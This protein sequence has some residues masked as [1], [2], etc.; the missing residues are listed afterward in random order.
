MK[1][2]AFVVLMIS[3]LALSDL[4]ANEVQFTVAAPNQVGVG[5]RFNVTFRLNKRPASFEGPATFNGFRLL[6]G[7]SQSMSSQTQWVNNQMTMSESYSF[8][9]TLEALTE[10]T[11]TIPV[12]RA[13]VDGNTHTSNQATVV[14]SGQAQQQAQPRSQQ[15]QPQ[16]QA[17]TQQNITDEDIFIRASLSNR[18]PWQGERVTL[19][20]KLYTRVG[21]SQFHLDKLPSFQGLWSEDVTASGQVQ[22]TEEIIDGQRYNVATLKQF[23]IFPQRSGEIRIDP[24]EVK[25]WIRLATTRRTGSL[26][27][28]FFGGALGGFETIERNVRSN[29]V[30]LNVRDLPTQNRPGTFSGSVG[31]LD[32]T[33]RISSTETKANEPVT[34]TVRISGSGNLRLVEKPE[35]SFPLNLDTFEPRI[36]DNIRAQSSGISGSR[37][38]EFLLIPRTGGVFEIPPVQFSFFDPA[39]QRFVTR[40]SQKF[41]LTVEGGTATPPDGTASIAQQEVEYLN[42][43]IRFIDNRIFRLY[44]VGALF[45]RST[46]FY[47]LLILP[48]IIFAFLLFFWRRNIKLQADTILMNNLRAEK[49]AKKR[50]KLAG[51]LL[52]QGNSDDFY[53]EIFKALWGY[54]SNKLSISIASLNKEVVADVFGKK[55]VSP[56]LAAKFIATLNE[57]EYARFAPGEPIAKM[58]ETYQQ[59]LE[60]IVVLEKELKNKK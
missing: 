13:V 35:I 21:V 30:V 38:F 24:L 55:G 1:I 19:T 4:Q 43:D 40:T 8:T 7:P 12:A 59:T 32:L 11:F 58:D 2:K 57:C 47:A 54:I 14:V 16:Q 50:L 60:T 46:L 31:N 48:V 39:S 29:A 34:L 52:K 42:T 3:V 18:N 27:D 9:Y 37:E 25:T 45:F 23:L 49:I 53:D 28:E 15:Q 41:T 5:Q 22:V 26:F 51:I 17:P 6:G 56:E 10:G 44:P 36:T 33:A 20:Y